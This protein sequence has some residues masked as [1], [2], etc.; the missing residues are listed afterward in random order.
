ALLGAAWALLSAGHG[1]QIGLGFFGLAML[2]TAAHSKYAFLSGKTPILP[3]AQYNS[4]SPTT[5]H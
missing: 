3:R 2:L 1:I 5:D 4:L